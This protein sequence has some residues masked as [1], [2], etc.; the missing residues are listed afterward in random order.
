MT[1]AETGTSITVSLNGVSDSITGINVDPNDAAVANLT[2]IGTQTAGTPFTIQVDVEDAHGNPTDKNC[3]ANFL[4]ITEDGG[5]GTY[6]SPNATSMTIGADIDQT[7]TLGEYV[8]NNITMF[9]SGVSQI[10]ISAC[11][12]VLADEAVTVNP[13]AV[14]DSVQVSSTGSQLLLH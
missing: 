8:S 1:Q 5:A 3:G 2:V 7:G 9:K 4:A 6:N 10:D 13:K 14:V 12:V 11:A